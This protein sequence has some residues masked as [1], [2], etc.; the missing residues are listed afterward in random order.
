MESMIQMAWPFILMAAIF[1][2]MI[3]RP[4]KR[5]QKKRADMLNALKVGTRIVTIGGIFGVITKVQED[6]LRIKVAEN[7]E[8]HIRRSAVGTVL[9]SAFDKDN[10]PKEETKEEVK[11]EAKAEASAEN[12]ADAA[13]AEPAAETSEESK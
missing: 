8:F 5:D 2:M 4:Q 11:E 9:T 10:S 3:Y 7:V 13:K 12:A 6:K 1:Y